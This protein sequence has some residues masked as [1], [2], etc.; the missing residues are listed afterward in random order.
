MSLFTFDIL[1]HNDTLFIEHLKMCEQK[2]KLMASLPKELLDASSSVEC[3]VSFQFQ[4]TYV[5]LSYSFETY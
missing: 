4:V 2:S 1:H 3:G 5:Y